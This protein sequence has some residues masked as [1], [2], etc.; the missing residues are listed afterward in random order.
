MRVAARSRRRLQGW[1]A[2]HGAQVSAARVDAVH[3]V[4]AL[5]GRG[6][7][8]GKADGAGVVDQDIDAA[9][10]LHGFGHRGQHR[11]LVPDVHLQCQRP[12]ACCLDFRCCAVDGAGQL[13][14]GL[15][16][17]GGDH[18]VGTVRR[19]AFGNCQPDAA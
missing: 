2:G 14:V 13:G 6:F 17:L 12:A 4:E 3:E 16:G 15:G 8:I 9:K 5:H 7:G 10:H 11:V 19:R 1:Q 18:D